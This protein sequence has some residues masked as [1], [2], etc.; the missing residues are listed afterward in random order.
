MRYRLGIGA[1]GDR[2]DGASTAE[3]MA[4]GA[5][6]ERSEFDRAH[7]AEVV[8]VSY[9]F[10]IDNPVRRELRFALRGGSW[11]IVIVAP[12]AADPSSLAI[13]ASHRA[14]VSYIKEEDLVYSHAELPWTSWV[15]DTVDHDDYAIIDT[16]SLDFSP[17]GQPAIAYAVYGVDV[18]D[19]FRRAAVYVDRILRG[20]KPADLPVQNPTK[21]ELAINLKTAKALG[22]TVPPTLLARADE[23]IE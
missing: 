3:V 10:P 5:P 2:F 9:H 21:Y 4:D 22:L 18:V 23:V 11:E 14:G 20:A 6:L 1:A 13:D 8:A 19:L 15:V 7:V 12:D 16:R 17:S